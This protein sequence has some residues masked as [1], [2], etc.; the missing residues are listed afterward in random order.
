MNRMKRFCEDKSQ[1]R[2][3]VNMNSLIND[4]VTLCANGL[5]Q[6]NITLICELEDN[7]PSIYVDQIQ[8]EQV[9]INL[10]RNSIDALISA[11]E[12]LHRQIIIQSKLTLK[13]KIQVC[14]ID[15]GEGIDEGRQQKIMTPFHTTKVNGMG[16]GLSISRSLMEAH[17]GELKFKSRP[18]NG[19]LF[20]FTLPIS[21]E[22]DECIL[23]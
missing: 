6:N 20:Y 9:L 8:I 1:Q 10:I 21:T 15:N 11:S 13:N 18:G 14:V 23:S 7:L 12:K 19:C 2:S 22:K 5:K 4:C 17:N 16:M 3:N